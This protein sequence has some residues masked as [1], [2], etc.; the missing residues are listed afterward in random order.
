MR[1][2]NT[3]EPLQIITLAKDAVSV[4]WGRLKVANI[5]GVRHTS[6]RSEWMIA[7]VR[8]WPSGRSGHEPTPSPPRVTPPLRCTLGAA[9]GWKTAGGFLSAAFPP[10][11]L[12]VCLSLIRVSLPINHIDPSFEG[13]RFPSP[14]P[15]PHPR[16]SR[17]GERGD[18]HE[19][20]VGDPRR[21]VCVMCTLL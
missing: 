21:C 16:P 11:C 1:P 15:D 10:R 5:L 13:I 8:T 4:A 12:G 3:S 17:G 9:R 7:D 20:A 18:L 19:T 2:L 6:S 14:T